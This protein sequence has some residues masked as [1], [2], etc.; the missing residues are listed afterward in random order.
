MSSRKHKHTVP[1]VTMARS[2]GALASSVH[3]GQAEEF[4]LELVAYPE[5]TA[6]SLWLKVG[7]AWVR[8][9]DPSDPVERAV[10]LAFAHSDKFEVR[11]WHSDG[12]IVGL[13][14]NSKK[15]A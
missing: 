12:E 5:G 9:D 6:R 4:W 7:N 1:D 11:V 3:V 15:S 10:S 8:L 2:A 14:A 13:V